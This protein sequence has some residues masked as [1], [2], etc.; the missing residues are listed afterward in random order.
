MMIPFSRKLLVFFLTLG[1][2]LLT[3]TSQE[4]EELPTA[5]DT[6]EP[7]VTE[8][9]LSLGT[10]DH[11]APWQEHLT[12]GPGDVLNFTLLGQPGSARTGVA[13]QPDGRIN[14]MEARDILATGLTIDELRATIDRELTN[15]YRARTIITPVSFNSKKFYILGKVV[16]KGVFTMDRPMTLL[17]AIAQSGGFET[18]QFQGQI[19]ELADLPRSFLVR[20]GERV[21]VNFERLFQQGDLSQNI[22]IEPNDY[23][24]FPSANNNQIYVLGAVVGPGVIAYAPRASAIAAISLSGGFTAAAYRQRVLVV[25]GSLNQP[26]TFIVNAAAIL[27]GREPDFRLEPKDI[28]YVSRRPWIKAEELLDLAARSFVQA[29]VAT[30]VGQNVDPLITE[31]IID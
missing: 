9:R 20:Q 12:L 31:P 7:P 14:Y 28:V 27:D 26:E 22:P 6:E 15:I 4:E 18:G 11:R 16:R 13:I 17:E 2:P 25:R 1:L 10:P 5:P 19:V 3:A 30:W 8:G 24:F 21:P 29:A 23:L